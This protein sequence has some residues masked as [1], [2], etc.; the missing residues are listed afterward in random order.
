MLQDLE[1][2]GFAVLR[3]C[4]IDE[5]GCSCPTARCHCHC[6]SLVTPGD[7]AGKCN[8]FSLRN[9]SSYHSMTLSCGDDDESPVLLQKWLVSIAVAIE[10][11]G[12]CPRQQQQQQQQQQ[13]HEYLW[14]G[15]VYKKGAHNT[16]WKKRFIRLSAESVT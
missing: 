14:Q 6:T 4:C 7:R 10:T 15:W 8:C 11:Q 16:A 2:L 9:T 1:P 12:G 13:Q 5:S 3:L